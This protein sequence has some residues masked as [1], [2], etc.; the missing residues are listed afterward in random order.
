MAI[1]RRKPKVWESRVPV[2]LDAALRE[3]VVRVT[4]KKPGTWGFALASIRAAR[5]WSLTGQAMALGVSE[6][7][8]V[9]LSVCRL[10]RLGRRDEDVATVAGRMGVPVDVLKYILNA[11]TAGTAVTR[12]TVIEGAA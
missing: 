10:P 12:T 9:F 5:G 6:S 8:L 7:A 3:C 2:V 1:N 4:A 11:T